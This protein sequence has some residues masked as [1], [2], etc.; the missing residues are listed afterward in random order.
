MDELRTNN[1]M[2]PSG[3]S[4]LLSHQSSDLEILV[5]KNLAFSI[6]SLSSITDKGMITINFRGFGT[7]LQLFPST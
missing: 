4:N 1:L 2:H 3:Y 5:G 6:L 7:L